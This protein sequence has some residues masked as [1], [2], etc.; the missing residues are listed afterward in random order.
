MSS[1]AVICTLTQEKR[2]RVFYFRI[3]SIFCSSPLSLLVDTRLQLARPPSIPSLSARGPCRSGGDVPGR[4]A[5]G[6]PEP[7]VCVGGGRSDDQRSFPHRKPATRFCDVKASQYSDV[8]AKVQPLHDPPSS[9]APHSAPSN[10]PIPHR[11][12]TDPQPPILSSFFK[13]RFSVWTLVQPCVCVCGVLLNDRSGGGPE[14]CWKIKSRMAICSSIT[15]SYPNAAAT[16]KG[17]TASSARRTQ[18][19]SSPSETGSNPSE[20]GSSPSGFTPLRAQ[21]VGSGIS[22]FKFR[23][24]TE[25]GVVS[26]SSIAS[27]RGQ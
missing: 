12:P 2:F 22:G 4:T 16:S 9:N 24:Q 26:V 11:H 19:G 8:L 23:F 15:L 21:S 7:G 5:A 10:P 17:S 27:M 14:K 6:P 20:T 25:V 3:F 1:I 13:N 18:P